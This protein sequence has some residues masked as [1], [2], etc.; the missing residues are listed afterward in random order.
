[1]RLC[2]RKS[3]VGFRTFTIV[4]NSSGITVLQFVGYWTQKVHPSHCNINIE[5]AQKFGFFS[6]MLQKNL[7]DLSG[8]SNN[9][10]ENNIFLP[11]GFGEPRDFM[12]YF[13]KAL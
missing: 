13:L 11:V 9:A 2:K 5:L 3:D 7:N 4:R 1:M 10:N 12:K 6:R 8:Q